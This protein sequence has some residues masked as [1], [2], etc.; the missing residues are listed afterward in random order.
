MKIALEASGG[1]LAR[2]KFN[3]YIK[4]WNFQTS[5]KPKSELATPTYIQNCISEMIGALQTWQ[6][7]LGINIAPEN[8]VII[9]QEQWNHIDKHTL[10]ILKIHRMSYKEAEVI[11]KIIY[12]PQIQ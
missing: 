7:S 3:Y 4:K 2:E 5:S 8:R 9:Q 11:Y 1:Q 12:N 10:N 6:R